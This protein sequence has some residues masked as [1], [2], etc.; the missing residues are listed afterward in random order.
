MP[1]KIALFAAFKVTN[2]TLECFGTFCVHFVQYIMNRKKCLNTFLLKYLKFIVTNLKL[3]FWRP[4]ANFQLWSQKLYFW[5]SQSTLFKNGQK[6][7][8]KSKRQKNFWIT[9]SLKI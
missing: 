2:I 5:E 9:F 7:C 1:V 3:F 6:K 8:P 4:H